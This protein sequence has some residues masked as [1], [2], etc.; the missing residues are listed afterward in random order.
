MSF[1]IREANSGDMDAVF[2]LMLEFAVFQ[3]TPD[4]LKI[5]PEQLRCDQEFFKC[6][7]ATVEKRIVGFAT[8]FFAY[9]SWTGR[10]IYL[11]DLYVQ[12]AYRT[13]GIGNCLFDRVA[14][15]GRQH[16]CKTMRWLVS[17]WNEKAKVFYTSKGAAIDV[18]DS[19]CTMNL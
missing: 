9:Y 6:L 12:D 4:K 2:S 8:Y 3:Q 5:N 7:V 10:G 17:D 15:L 11:D 1:E 18:V 14:A 19:V 16:E 13:V